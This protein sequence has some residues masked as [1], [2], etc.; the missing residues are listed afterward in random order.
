MNDTP[1]AQDPGADIPRHS[2]RARAIHWTLAALFIIV[3]AT[4]LS[5]YWRSILGWALPLF[6]G[7]P[8]AIN[9]HF[10]GGAGL[11]LFT[12][13]LYFLWRR[14]ARWTAAD[15]DFV[16][17]LPRYA[18]GASQEPPPGTGFF[19]GGQKLYFWAV[20]AGGL[21]LFATGVVWWFRKDVPPPVYVVCR[22]S[23]RI[24]AVAMSGAL[25]VHVYKATIG[26]P[27]TLR[28]ILRGTVTRDWARRR[29]PGWYR[30]LGGRS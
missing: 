22:T 7:K 1:T 19:N 15:T 20:V 23:H 12:V 13:L 25:L 17:H 5:L 16:R 10:W 18:A 11:T 6:G 27:G 24:L 21:V 29:R 9:I 14:A 3:M 26:E 2:A 4:G 8:S 30:D 28:S